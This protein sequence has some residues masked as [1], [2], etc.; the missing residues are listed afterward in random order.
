MV[1]V[2]HLTLSQLDTVQNMGMSSGSGSRGFM[3]LRSQRA[4]SQCLSFQCY[5]LWNED[6]ICI[7]NLTSALCEITWRHDSVPVVLSPRLIVRVIKIL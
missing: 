1:Y 6:A 2:D 7:S 3:S 5:S 4:A